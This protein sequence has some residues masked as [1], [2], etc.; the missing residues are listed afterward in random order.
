MWRR[1]RRVW[2]RYGPPGVAREEVALKLPRK[3]R[4]PYVAGL[5]RGE[6]A[7]PCCEGVYIHCTVLL[8][9]LYPLHELQ[10]RH[11]GARGLLGWDGVVDMAKRA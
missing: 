10:H 3:R 7:R 4:R 2:K 8:S 1:P 11:G 5:W 9:L 6:M